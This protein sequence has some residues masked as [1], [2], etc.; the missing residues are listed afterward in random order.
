ME[1]NNHSGDLIIRFDTQ[2]EAASLLA[3]LSGN[4]HTLDPKTAE[5]ANW[6]YAWFYE[7]VRKVATN[8]DKEIGTIRRS[9]TPKNYVPP[10]QGTRRSL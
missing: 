10:N 6:L 2:Q 4:A 3:V 1:V 9:M 7:S 8:F 5:F